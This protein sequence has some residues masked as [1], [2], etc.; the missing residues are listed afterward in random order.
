M[1]MGTVS[2]METVAAKAAV[3]DAKGRRTEPVP[4]VSEPLTAT[5]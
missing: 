4:V 2:E 3:T 1:L 5:Q